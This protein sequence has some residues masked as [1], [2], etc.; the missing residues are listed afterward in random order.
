MKQVNPGRLRRSLSYTLQKK[1]ADYLSVAS[2][3]VSKKVRGE[4]AVP[5]IHIKKLCLAV[6]KKAQW[7]CGWK[8]KCAC[9]ETLESTKQFYECEK[10]GKTTEMWRKI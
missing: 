2:A 3:T 1:V 9:G 5:H 6:D 10:C 7:L 8:R 4:R